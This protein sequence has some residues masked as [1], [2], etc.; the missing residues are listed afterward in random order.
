M[1][2]A[3]GADYVVRLRWRSFRLREPCGAKFDLIAHLQNMPKEQNIDDISVLIERAG[4]PNSNPL[5]TRIVIARKP[6]EAAR[7]ERERQMREARKKGKQLD[8]RSLIAAE[9]V[10]LATSL[11]ENAYPAS[12]ILAL[13]RLRWQI[14][15]AF[16][17]LKTLLRIDCLP[18]KTDKGGRSW[19]YAHLILAIATD[20]CS[21]DFLN[22][23]PDEMI[24]ADYAPSIWRVQ[25]T[26]IMVLRIAILGRIAL[27]AVLA[28]PTRFHRLLAEPPRKRKLQLQYPVRALS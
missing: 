12:E 10:M 22:S 2:Q 3:K 26:V 19:I 9:Y 11:P 25:K 18:A 14:E 6:E 27:N 13:Y 28:A 20:A 7:A 4:D 21:Q 5:S 24:A 8:P 17:R 16:K 23:P 15:L 1:K